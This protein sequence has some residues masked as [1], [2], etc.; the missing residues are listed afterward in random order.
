M[1]SACLCAQFQENTKESHLK[2]VKKIIKYS[3]EHVTMDYG[4]LEE[5][6][7]IYVLIWIQI[8][9]DLGMIRKHKWSILLSWQLSCL[10]AM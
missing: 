10:M 7:L 3:R 1:L 5:H 6:I 9:L 4:I 2:A 8:M